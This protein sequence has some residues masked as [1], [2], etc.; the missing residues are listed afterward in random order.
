M[1]T[2]MLPHKWW[3]SIKHLL[4]GATDVPERRD[5]TLRVTISEADAFTLPAGVIKLR[6]VRGGAWV[7]HLREDLIVRCG[8]TLQLRPD[9]HGIVVTSIGREPVELELYR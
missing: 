6:V 8:Q 7:S 4:F 1:T 9:R 5:C 2:Q 3:R